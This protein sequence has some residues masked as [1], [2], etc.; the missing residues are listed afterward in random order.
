MLRLCCR[1]VAGMLQVCCAYVAA[2]LRPCC[3]YVAGMLQ[4]C[5]GTL[6]TVDK[7][8]NPFTP[9]KIFGALYKVVFLETLYL[10]GKLSL[11]ILLYHD[12]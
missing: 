2:M 4:S 12:Y 10:C 3:A 9:N 7:Y 6:Q 5:Y 8:C 1:Y 11:T